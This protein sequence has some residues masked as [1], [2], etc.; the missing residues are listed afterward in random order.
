M[1]TMKSQ[2][3]YALYELMSRLFTIKAAVVT[4]FFFLRGWYFA[5][6]VQAPVVQGKWWFILLSL[7]R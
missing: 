4:G 2:Y 5:G 7:T 1:S 6:K 3:Y